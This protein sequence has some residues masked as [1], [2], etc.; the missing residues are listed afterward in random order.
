MNCEEVNKKIFLYIEGNYN[1][2][3]ESEFNEHLKVCKKCSELYNV[4]LLSMSIIEEEKQ[5]EGNPFIST[6]IIAKVN[7]KKIKKPVLK[8]VLQPL[9]ATIVVFL[10]IWLG[11]NISDFYT[12]SENSKIVT[13][14]EQSVNQTEQYVFNDFSYEEYFFIANQ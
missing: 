7:E 13:E 3:E 11:R 4:Y 12:N 6:Q 8:L 2:L 9:L 5:I 10:G 1:K 14:Y